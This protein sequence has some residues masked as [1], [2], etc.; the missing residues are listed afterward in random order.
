MDEIREFL[1]SP[2]LRELISVDDMFLERVP[3]GDSLRAGARL[4]IFHLQPEKS[5][6]P[7]SGV[8]RRRVFLSRLNP[9]LSSLNSYLAGTARRTAD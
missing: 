2:Y 6:G 7:V 4:L 1:A 3:A 5:Y 9:A 8:R